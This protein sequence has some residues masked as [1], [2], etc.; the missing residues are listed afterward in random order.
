MLSNSSHTITVI[1]FLLPMA[2]PTFRLATQKHAGVGLKWLSSLTLSLLLW[3]LWLKASAHNTVIPIQ[4]HLVSFP[5]S[6]T[7][8]IEVTRVLLSVCFSCKN[9][10]LKT[11]IHIYAC[12]RSRDSNWL[13]AGWQRGRSS[14]SVGSRIF[15]SSSRPDRPSLLSIGYQGL[16][17]RG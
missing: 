1:V 4:T 8:L 16:F 14:S 5:I 11:F 12:D 6:W 7:K 3:L 15:S 17:P 13:Q 10:A 2:T 9:I